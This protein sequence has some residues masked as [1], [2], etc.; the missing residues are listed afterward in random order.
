[1]FSLLEFLSNIDNSNGDA[2]VMPEQKDEYD[3]SDIL[4]MNLDGEKLVNKVLGQK[5]FIIENEYPFVCD[6]FKISGYDTLIEKISRTSIST[7]NNN[8]LLNTGNIENYNIFL[9]LA[10]DVLS[11]VIKKDLPENTTLKIYYPFLYS[12]NIKS[13]EKLQSSEAKLIDDDMEFLNPK[14][15]ES[16][17]TVD[18][19]YDIYKY[20]KTD[21]NYLKKGIKFIK[22]VIKPKFIVKIPLDVIFK[23]IHS[24][25]NNPLIKY[26]PSSRQEN[27]YRLYTDQIAADGKKIPF[28]KKAIIFNLIKNI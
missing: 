27:I 10:N 24:T 11:N 19:F 23:I 22:A 28:L 7:L 14:T 26:N 20:K 15:L 4:G 6:P 25:E 13:F 16:F 12:K 18:M 3:L 5:F 8:L 2:F 17:K 1:L 21:L 9:C